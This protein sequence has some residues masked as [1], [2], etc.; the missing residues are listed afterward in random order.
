MT[1]NEE[2]ELLTLTRN[3]NHILT[4]IWNILNSPKD[5]MKDL[6]IN[7]IANLVADKINE[8]NQNSFNS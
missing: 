8:R 1:I 6:F 2:Q 5:D 4:E 7:I 3:N